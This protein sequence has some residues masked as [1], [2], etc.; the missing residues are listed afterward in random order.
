MAMINRLLSCRIVFFIVFSCFA[1]GQQ[2]YFPNREV[3]VSNLPVRRAQSTDA[4][5]TLF[6]ALET[7]LNT[8][9]VCCGKESALADTL[10]SVN[11]L[12]LKEVSSKLQGRHILND[13]QTV[14]LTSEYLSPDLINADRII[15]SLTKQHAFVMEWNSRFYVLYGAVFDD[16]VDEHG[17]RDFFIHKLLLID[18]RY[19]GPHR[20]VLFNRGSD[21]FAKVQGLVRLTATPE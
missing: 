16:T 4:R 17:Q 5:E 7:V 8:P 2:Q 14:T 3:R 13:G 15:A 11:P 1:L 19:S 18:V 21:D 10:G 6:A 12:S 9:D 20:E